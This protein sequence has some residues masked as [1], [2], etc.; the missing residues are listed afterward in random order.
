MNLLSRW[1]L[2]AL[3]TL[4]FAVPALAAD[5]SRPWPQAASDLP[6]DP[7]V[8]FGT[9]PNGM[10]YAIRR[11]TTPKGAVSVRLRIDAGSLM[12]R[13]DEQGI[14]HLMEHMA[15][16]GSKRVAD[17]DMVK[18]LQSLGLSFGADTNAFTGGTQTVYSF[19]MPKNDDASIDTSLMLMREIA[20]EANIT[21]EAMAT[22]RNVVLAEAHLGDVPSTHLRKADFQ[23]LYGDRPAS[24]LLPIGLEKIVANATPELVRGFYEAWYRPERATLIVVGDID[25][26][27]VEAQIKAK[28]SDWKAAA[29]PR[30]V[31]AYHARA[32]HS[33]RAKIFV[34]PG[35]QA[36]IAFDWLKP[37]DDTPDSKAQERREVIR[38]IALG[39][40]NQRLAALAHGANPPFLAASASHDNVGNFA[41]Q[42]ELGIS[43]RAGEN[44]EGLKAVERVWRDA[45]KNGVRQDE[46]DRY[47]SELRA[48]FQS[49]ADSADSTPTPNV[50]NDILRSVDD[51]TVYTSSHYDLESYEDIVKSLT[52][53][54]VSDLLRDSFSG[55]GPYLFV[56]SADALPGG[57][58]ALTDALAQAD[59]TPLAASTSQAL[60]PWPYGAFGTP[61]KVESRRE[62][63]DLGV[64]FVKFAN[65]VTLTVKPTKLRA[66]QVLVHVDFGSGRLSL[67][68]DR[69]VPSWALSGSFIQGGLKKLSIDDL[70]RAMA[71]RIWGASFAMAD[72]SFL[73]SAST[74]P[75]DLDRELQVLTAY[76][77]DAAWRPEAFEQNQVAAVAGYAQNEAAPASV[78]ARE[79]SGL[80]HSGDKRFLAATLAEIK[81]AALDDVKAIIAKPLAGGPLDVTIVGDITVD[82]AIAAVAGTLGALP[83]RPAADPLA[84]GHERFPAPV[85][86]P[87]TLTHSGAPNQ[88]IT[89]IAWPTN[90]FYIDMQAPRTLRVLS[91]IFSTRLID[92]LR[93]REGITYSPNASTYASLNTDDYGFIYAVAQIPPDKIPNF[94]AAIAAT[95]A[96]L[97]DH[98]V[99]QLELD[100]AR[101]PRIQDIQRQ[102]QSNEYWVSLL[103]GAGVDPRKLDVIRT[104]IPDEEKITVADVQKAADLWLKDAKSWK[105]VV[106]PAAAKP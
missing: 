54:E 28:F 4:S 93:T 9:L 91:E 38:Y 82:Q 60:I 101:G 68:T 90:G 23:F 77:T 43:Y 27:A 100:R 51:Q 36:F 105:L 14:A 13:D 74:R 73:L 29:P 88:A 3:L 92:Q 86:D 25:P 8:R 49:R 87:V 11:N 12:E 39:V 99:S 41:E 17:G 34:E 78:L 104:T 31:P 72:D 84:K 98:P 53:A 44:L 6:A 76:I 80:V 56:S 10:R 71:D 95:A 55:D 66:G 97:R 63:A 50:I 20:S 7:A 33:D 79:F 35:A 58:K 26:A 69:T 15:F 18:T 94:Y 83:E 40:I 47:V 61:A 22:E 96:D 48:F 75:A 46:V 24:A 62:V 89:L 21:K 30:P 16:R 103:D 32:N 85:S 65:G 2:A 37:F 42:T 45:V 67:P 59:A 57:E 52:A 81:G 5:P 64:T 106:V 102:Q 19:D 1:T 70:Q